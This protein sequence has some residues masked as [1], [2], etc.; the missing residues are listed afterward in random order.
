MT[1]TTL[2]TPTVR[3]LHYEPAP[4]SQAPLTARGRVV[5]PT[6]PYVLPALDERTARRAVGSTLRLAIEV[7]DGRRTPD[8]LEA[9]LDPSPL[10]YWRAEAARKRPGAASR[11][12]RLRVFLPHSDAAEV[13]AVCRIDGRVRALAARFER[14]GGA[15]CCAVLRLA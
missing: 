9:R 12:L 1:T 10:G 13:A 5:A 2:A 14:R 3:R 6:E 11:V 15:W 4:G 7:L 8:Q